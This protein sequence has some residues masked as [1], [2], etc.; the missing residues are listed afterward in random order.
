MTRG[1][2]RPGRFIGLFGR[3]SLAGPGF[4]PDLRR[5]PLPISKN[6]NPALDLWTLCCGPSGLAPGTATLPWE[7]P[8]YKFLNV[9]STSLNKQWLY[10]GGIWL[11]H[12]TYRLSVL[13][14]Q[15][16]LV[17]QYIA[18]YAELL[19]ALGSV[20][21]NNSISFATNYYYYYLLLLLLLLLNA[22]TN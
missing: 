22:E 6:R 12:G 7:L 15:R 2:L 3:V 20:L 19:T 16:I 1:C 10:Y 14:R 5:V 4:R 8:A 13:V 9:G 21:Q 18:R 11:S 17:L